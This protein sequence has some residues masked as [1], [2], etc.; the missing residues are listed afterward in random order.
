MICCLSILVSFGYQSLI[1]IY[2]IKNGEGILLKNIS[3]KG[4]IV[5]LIG[6]YI[7]IMF[8]SLLQGKIMA[9]AVNKIEN[10]LDTFFFEKLM[11]LPL[12]YFYE[13]ESGGVLTRF[14]DI[15]FIKEVLSSGLLSFFMN[16][17]MLIVGVIFLLQIN[18]R[19]FLVVL[20][21]CC[22]YTV[23]LLLYKR[24]ME[25]TN[26]LYME[27]RTKLISN[28]K[29][30]VDGIDAV[31][32]FDLAVVFSE[33]F[34]KIKNTFLLKSFKVD[35]L[36]VTQNSI[37][38][39]IEGIGNV[40]ILLIGSMLVINHRMT[41]GTLILFLSLMNYFISPV[42][43]ILALQPVIM[44]TF[45]TAERLND[46]FMAE[47]ESDIF[48]GTQKL[49]SVVGEIC[50]QNMNF[51]YTMGNDVLK[52][53]SMCI[54]PFNHVALVGESGCGKSTLIKLIAA[55]YP[56]ERGKI[57]L[58][59]L[60]YCE[61]SIKDLRAN[62][63]YVSQN[64]SLFQGTIRENLCVG[65]DVDDKILTKVCR[66]CL[67]DEMF[68]QLPNGI[69]T[70]VGEQGN[71]LSGGQKQRIIVARALLSNSKILLFDEAMGHLDAKNEKQIFSYIHNNYKDRT[72]IFVTHNLQIA[73][74]CDDIYLLKNGK[75]QLQGAPCKIRKMEEY[76]YFCGD[77]DL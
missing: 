25:N 24:P 1:D 64:T 11:K 43:S 23:V 38:T 21:Y 13:R 52:N 36:G 17:M 60:D 31:K 68:E 50:I 49:N 48:W 14:Q 37:V 70:N 28:V 75:I 10:Q 30:T 65:R 73:E 34:N 51:Q 42:Q 12:K 57:F 72:C 4:L 19:L 67:L 61:I 20:I 76:Q 35:S 8:L 74:M 63:T 41:L 32:G 62:I 47:N 53:L 7:G 18:V 2:L 46:V 26:R 71:L 16:C 69:N 9:T 55:I 59:G 54:K 44:E 29:S 22:S 5:L 6:S 40:V 3:F 27:E 58:D 39:G 77:G 33:R 66:G 45:I 15:T 56:F